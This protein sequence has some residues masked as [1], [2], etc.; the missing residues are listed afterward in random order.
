MKADDWA[1]ARAGDYSSNNG[2]A[3]D[4]LTE[5][6]SPPP[7]VPPAPPKVATP[8]ETYEVITPINY[9][10]DSEYS[11]GYLD[12]LH[13][14]NP[15]GKK[16]PGTYIVYGEKTNGMIN[17]TEENHKPGVWINPRENVLA[18]VPVADVI[19]PTLPVDP[20]PV[21]VSEPVDVS[22]N[23]Q[24]VTTPAPKTLYYEW[25]R[26]DRK[27]VWYHTKNVQEQRFKDL[28]DPDAPQV[29]LPPNKDI[30][31][32]MVTIKGGGD[33][34]IPT[35]SLESGHRHG[36]PSSLLDEVTGHT[37]LDYNNDGKVNTAD[38]IDGIQGFVDY[39][40]K[41]FGVTKNTLYKVAANPK[42][43]QAKVKLIDG[44]TAGKRKAK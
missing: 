29:V 13:K 43:S 3:S 14:Q 6:P 4:D 22:D 32:S 5:L 16:Q 10:E 17:I 31:F 2:I 21:P 8:P 30:R 39:G 26:G 42:I 11:I 35:K 34:L 44:F 36:V 38:F 28:E 9:Y 40:S 19:V 25:L 15:I 20:P 1:K 41:L 7:Y 37:A 12:A 27:P 18:P 24:P 33:W 23:S